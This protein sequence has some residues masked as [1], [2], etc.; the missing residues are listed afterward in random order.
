MAWLFSSAA[1]AEIILEDVEHRE[2]VNIPSEKSVQQL[3]VYH[4]ADPVKGRVELKLGKGIKKLEHQG[5]RVD[6]IG[7]IE[8]FYDRGSH[9]QFLS[10]TKP[11]AQ[12]GEIKS[13]Q[14][15]EFEFLSDNKTSESYN[16]KNAILRYVKCY[17]SACNFF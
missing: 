3:Y 17:L 13:D 12:P 4:G 2:I 5:I 15:F 7:Q 6:F 9:F 11:L 8:L 10:L 1:K 16:G 14:V